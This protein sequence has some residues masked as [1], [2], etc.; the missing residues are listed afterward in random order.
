MG[1][2]LLGGLGF[3]ASGNH[4]AA[5]TASPADVQATRIAFVTSGVVPSAVVPTA[6][7]QTAQ[8]PTRLRSYIPPL[9]WRL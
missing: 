1:A 6:A 8:P 9:Y 5:A 2:I 3:W 7:R 4:T